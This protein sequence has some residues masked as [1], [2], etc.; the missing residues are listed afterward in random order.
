MKKIDLRAVMAPLLGLLLLLG[1]R[2]DGAQ[3]DAAAAEIRKEPFAVAGHQAFVI[4]PPE[5]KI[6]PIPWVLYA[7]TLGTN[8]PGKSEAWMFERFLSAGIAIAGVNVGES[9]GSPAGR[10]PYTA[11]YEKLVKDEGFDTKVSLLARSR[12]GLMLYCWAAENPEKIR[13]ITGIYPVCNLASYPGLGRACGAYGMTQGQLADALVKHNPGDRLAPLAAAGVPIFHIHGDKDNVVPLPANS[14]LVAERYKAAGGLMELEVA[15]GQGHNMWRGFFESQ[16]LVNFLVSYAADVPYG[17]VGSW[18]GYHVGSKK[19]GTGSIV[20]VAPSW[21]LTA[22]HVATVKARA[23]KTRNVKVAFGRKVEVQVEEAFI[24]PKGDIALVR[25]KRA[26]KGIQPVGVL[27]Q[28][29]EEKHGAITFTMAGHQGGR[30][31]HPGRRGIG[32]GLKFRHYPGK[33]GTPGKGG[34]SGGAFVIDHP[35]NDRDVLFGIVSGGVRIGG[36]SYGRGI[37]PAAVRGWIDRT[38]TK[39]GEK[40]RWVAK[41]KALLP[42]PGKPKPGKGKKAG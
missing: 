23:P 28:V 37:Q 15:S 32:R 35:G 3:Q 7:P 20:M 1:G 8:L 14:G 24:A 26:L 10:K 13:C 25:F 33:D 41:S 38:M 27:S 6:E 18:R 40:V 36:K 34:D 11:L 2:L 42:A 30:H 5:K 29:L 31:F 22:A 4:R 21:G 39:S 19:I 9:Y 12:G 16:R 17:Y